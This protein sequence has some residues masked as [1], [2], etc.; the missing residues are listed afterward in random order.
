MP[1]ITMCLSHECPRRGTCYRATAEPHPKH[2]SWSWYLLPDGTCDHYWRYR[3]SLR[4]AESEDTDAE[5][6]GET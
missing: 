4:R 3:K 5:S 1:N 6:E 2:Q